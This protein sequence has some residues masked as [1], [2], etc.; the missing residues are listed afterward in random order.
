EFIARHVAGFEDYMA[1]ARRYTLADA[2]RI[3]GIDES[4][5]AQL[6]EWYRTI[7][8]AVITVGNGLERNKNGGSG[9][10]A[11]FAVPALA[12]QFGVPGGGL[13]NARGCALAKE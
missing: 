13:I 5:V 1:L 9:I 4:V 8:P 6:A 11:I 10:R 12:G 7:S 2:A 3:C